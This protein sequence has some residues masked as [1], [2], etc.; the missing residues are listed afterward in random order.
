MGEVD[1]GSIALTQFNPPVHEINTL[2]KL[3]DMV[4]RIEA[5][6]WIVAV[7]TET[8]GL[9][10]YLPGKHIRTIQFCWDADYGGCYVPLNIGDGCYWQINGT[11]LNK[12]VEEV[13][14]YLR[15]AMRTIRAQHAPERST[16]RRLSG[17]CPAQ[18]YWSDEEWPEVG[19]ILRDLMS[20]A[21]CIWHNGKFDR[22]WLHLWGQREFGFPILCPNILMDSM[23][24]AHMLNENRLV[25][26]KK[27][28]HL[29]AWISDL[30]YPGQTYQGPDAVLPIR[31][32]GHCGFA[33][34]RLEIQ[35]RD[36]L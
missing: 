2:K 27:V 4:A 5:A 32:K 26:L 7:D 23:H 29:R 8:D 36:A 21:K 35:R 3:R 11:E 17:K 34:S 19:L 15:Y 16:P 14:R 25:K 33:T 24:V 9:N 6:D 22:L 12:R 1:E 30:R 10:P 20:K 18:A 28:N 31:R 13:P